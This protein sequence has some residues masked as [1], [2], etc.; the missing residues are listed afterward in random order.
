MLFTG[1]Y[2]HVPNIREISCLPLV[3]PIAHACSFDVVIAEVTSVALSSSVVFLRCKENS[4]VQ[5]MTK[6]TLF[7]L[8]WMTAIDIIPP[9]I[10]VTVS[11]CAH[12]FSGFQP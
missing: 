10:T 12:S 9:T 8:S 6:T 7:L 2:S 1:L 5:K 11:H 3:Y 4:R